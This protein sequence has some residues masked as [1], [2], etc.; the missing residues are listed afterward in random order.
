MARLPVDHERVTPHGAYAYWRSKTKRRHAGVDLGGQRGTGVVAPEPVTVVEV[1]RGEDRQ[2]APA[3]GGVGLTGYG[4]AAVVGVGA[5]G[6]VHVL[7]HLDADADLPQLGAQ[8]GEGERVGQISELR[9]VHW[10]VRK[11]DRSPW[12]KHSRMADTL[13][14]LAWLSGF[15]TTA[16]SLPSGSRTPGLADV[17][18]AAQRVTDDIRARATRSAVGEVV[19]LVVLALVLSS[20]RR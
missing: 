5:S 13:D 17:L 14:P 2:Y 3:F 6:V 9:H 10:E 11:P 7:G 19:G 20:R 4:P 15:R 8:L 12:P 16:S 18:D 1:M